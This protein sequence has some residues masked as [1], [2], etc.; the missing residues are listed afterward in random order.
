MRRMFPRE[1]PD[2]AERLAEAERR[3]AAA[4]ER[5]ARQSDV[6]GVERL[7]RALAAYKERETADRREMLADLWRRETPLPGRW[8]G[9]DWIV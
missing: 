2:A 3:I 4:E 6:Q 5:I 8:R 7:E 1:R 9:L